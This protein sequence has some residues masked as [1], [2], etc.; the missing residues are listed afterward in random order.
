M[1]KKAYLP[2]FFVGGNFSDAGA[3]NDLQAM[4]DD[5]GLEACIYIRT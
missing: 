2:G 4:S 5:P 1:S 3:S